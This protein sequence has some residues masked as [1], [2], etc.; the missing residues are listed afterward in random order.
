MRANQPAKKK[1]KPKP[2]TTTQQYTHIHVCSCNFPL[3][4]CFV[5]YLEILQCLRPGGAPIKQNK[6]D[7]TTQATNELCVFK[8]IRH[9]TW[10]A[11]N[12][13]LKTN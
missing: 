13:K 9:K 7:G 4:L 5:V 11:V 1:Q 10:D 6:E 3:N 2:K 12:K 8:D